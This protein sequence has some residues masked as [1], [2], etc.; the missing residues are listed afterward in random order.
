[1]EQFGRGGRP[2]GIGAQVEKNR[3]TPGTGAG[4]PSE[5][6]ALLSTNK[7]HPEVVEEWKWVKPTKPGT[8]IR[9]HDG[10]TPA[11]ANPDRV[12]K[13][14][15]AKGASL[16]DPPSLQLELLTERRCGSIIFTKE[17]TSTRPP[18][19]LSFAR[20]LPQILKSRLLSKVQSL[21]IPP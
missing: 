12:V 5:G 7:R 14:T 21:E 15:F 9:S 18:S 19:R 4:T 1:M 3:R 17:K 8:P 10:T 11:P 2:V 20:R 6:E 16:K 13:L